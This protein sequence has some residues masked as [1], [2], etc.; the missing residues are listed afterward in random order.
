M[1]ANT[2]ISKPVPSEKVKKTPKAAKHP[3]SP[4]QRTADATAHDETAI[5]ACLFSITFKITA[6]T[7]KLNIDA[8][9]DA[10][11]QSYP[12]RRLTSHSPTNHRNCHRNFTRTKPQ[13]NHQP[14]R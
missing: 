14:S 13:P 3:P 4:I 2:R 6:H 11:S 12:S 5:T 7:E 9:L 8:I 1:S 10:S